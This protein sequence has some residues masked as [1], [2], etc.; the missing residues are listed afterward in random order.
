MPFLHRYINII[1]MFISMSFII[2]VNFELLKLN[3]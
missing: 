1:L 2:S 3:V